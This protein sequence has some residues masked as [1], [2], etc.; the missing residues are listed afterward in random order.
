[1]AKQQ[2][3]A[4]HKHF[5]TSLDCVGIRNLSILDDLLFFFIAF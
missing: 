3:F 4:R 1:M 5:K 2:S